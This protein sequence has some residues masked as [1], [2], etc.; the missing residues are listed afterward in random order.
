MVPTKLPETQYIPWV[1]PS[2]PPL[3][4][5]SSHQQLHL[6]L[7]SSSPALLPGTLFLHFLSLYFSHLVLSSSAPTE[8]IPPP[9]SLTLSRGSFPPNISKKSGPRHP[10]TPFQAFSH[11]A[12]LPELGHGGPPREPPKPRPAHLPKLKDQQLPMASSWPWLMKKLSNET[13]GKATDTAAE[14]C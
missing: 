2:L 4:N 10:P 9:F 13:R 11:L 6:R 3:G 5:N 12:P 14:R 8:V 1:D 7:S